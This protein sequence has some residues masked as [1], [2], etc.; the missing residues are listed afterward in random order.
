MFLLNNPRSFVWLRLLQN[1]FPV[2]TN[3]II[4]V[5][6]SNMLSIASFDHTLLL[7]FVVL[8]YFSSYILCEQYSPE[9][10][11]KG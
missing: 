4:N 6:I 2:Y 8:F 11:K 10:L 7:L 3:F 5:S 9:I 1:S